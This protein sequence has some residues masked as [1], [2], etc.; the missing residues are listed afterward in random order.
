MLKIAFMEKDL[1]PRSG[2]RRF[3]Y[4]V[5]NYLNA[6]GH[7]VRCFTLRLDEKTC[8]PEFLSLPVKVVPI[9]AFRSFPSRF[10][11]HAIGRDVDYLWLENQAILEIG[12]RV[13]EWDPDAAVFHYAGGVW[14]Q[15]YFYYFKEPVGTVCLHVTPPITGPL[16]LP[17][18][19]LTM[20][21]KLRRV[22]YRFP[23]LKNW[24]A[25]ST[26]NL[27]LIIAHSR[28]LLTEALKQGVVGSRSSAMVP[29]AVNHSEFHPTGE[30]ESFALYLGRIHPHKS[31]EL[32]V[33]AMEKTAPDKSLIIAGDLE[34]EYLWYKRRLEHIAERI[35]VSDRFKIVVSPPNEEV[36]RL[37]QRCAVFLFPSTIDT[38]GLVVLE[39]MACGKPVVACNRGGA[40]EL[41]HG[42]GF[43]LEPNVKQW[44]RKVKKL[45]SDPDLRQVTG[46]KALERSKMYSW[47]NTAN[48][49]LN[50]LENFL[51]STRGSNH[52]Q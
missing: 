19:D 35:G 28:Y 29:L 39:A 14:L 48:S 50:V 11:K 9:D 6:Q 52:K 49:L 51:A 4:E 1:S 23:P 20:R 45:L 16:A 44:Q 13:V 33:M 47:E 41:L 17:F 22:L 30:E 8:F 3:I 43:L 31:L 40:P 37:M 24:R 32:A 5:T 18:Q 42:C 27:G 38:F 36:V 21:G 15:P 7:E 34:P 2:S 46:R 12:R 10:L 25:V 26:G